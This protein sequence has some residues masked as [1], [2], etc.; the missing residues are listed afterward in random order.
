MPTVT[1]QPGFNS[2]GQTD[3]AATPA[4]SPSRFGPRHCGHSA[5]ATAGVL[6]F[7]LVSPEDAFT[8][9]ATAGVGVVGDVG[10]AVGAGVGVAASSPTSEA[11]WTAAPAAQAERAK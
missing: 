8:P 10:C 7:P 2:F 6:P 11:G 1:F 4:A 5:V 3:G 9:S